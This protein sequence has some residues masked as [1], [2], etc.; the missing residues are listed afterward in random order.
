MENRLAQLQSMIT[1]YPEDTFL[2]YAIGLEYW[3]AG[4]LLEAYTHFSY[5]RQAKPEYL[6]TYYQ[7]GKLCSE[8]DRPEE[9]ASVLQEGMAVARRQEDYKTLEELQSA[10][11]IL[12]NDGEEDDED[13]EE[14]FS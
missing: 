13:E 10:L 6:P 2:N 4:K 14:A 11:R 3:T 5:L 12:E 7:L 8:T 1:D 9:A